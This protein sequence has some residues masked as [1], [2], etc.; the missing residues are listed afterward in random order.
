MNE[1]IVQP[2]NEA[3]AARP[4]CRCERH[5]APR[6]IVLTGGPGAGKTAVLEMLAHLVCPHVVITREAAGIL[7]SG[8]FPRHADAPT[9]R[10]VQRAIF[11][12][13]VELE[14]LASMGNPALVL[15]DRGLIDGCAYW[16]GPES[17]WDALGVT[18]EEALER[19]DAVI[20]LRTPTGSN[21][22]GHQNPMR[23]ETADEARAIDERIITAWEGHPRRFIVA[24]TSDFVSKAAQAIALILNEVPLCCRA[25]PD[26]SFMPANAQP[27]RASETTSTGHAAPWTTAPTTL[28]STAGTTR[29]AP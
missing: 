10:A 27:E 9:R 3:G 17:F 23:I 8:G 5:H 14:T 19:Y 4:A 21:G 20:H 7:F 6:R 22:Y 15:C 28:P 25:L 29:P 18:R 12:V 2:L 1:N 24:A 11:H 13:Q 26:I 16:P